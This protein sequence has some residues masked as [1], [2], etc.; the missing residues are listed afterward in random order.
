MA[1]MGIALSVL[2]PVIPVGSRIDFVAI[3]IISG[4]FALFSAVI[5]RAAIAS[6][7]GYC[8]VLKQMDDTSGTL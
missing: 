6:A 5:Y 3:G 1:F 4:S 2:T 7:G 8:K